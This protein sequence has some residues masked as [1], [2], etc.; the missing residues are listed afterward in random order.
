MDSRPERRRLDALQARLGHFFRDV[1]LLEHALTHRSAALE[2]GW[3]AEASYER[4]EFLGDALLNAWMAQLLFDKFPHSD[5]G[6][7]T[8]LRAYWVSGPVLAARARELD[9]PACLAV[10]EGGRRAG[11]ASQERVQASSFEALLAA[12]HLDAGGRRAPSL[13]RALWSGP[14]ASRGLEVLQEDAKTALQERRQAEGRSLP[15]Y[16]C[17]VQGPGFHAEVLLDGLRAGEGSGTTKKAAEQAAARAALAWMAPTREAEPARRQ[18]G[19]G[20]PP[21]R[22][23]RRRR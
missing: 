4:L 2:A 1:T 9:L 6:V 7:L 20:E 13:V 10:G 22:K 18:E 14:I 17:R 15:A 8:R 11:I 16:R 5:E 12:L 21:L 3:T 23:G 19:G